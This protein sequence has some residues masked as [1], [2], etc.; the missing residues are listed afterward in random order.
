[1]PFF[2]EA[3]RGVGGGGNDCIQGTRLMAPKTTLRAFRLDRSR[4]LHGGGGLV[5]GLDFNPQ[6]WWKGKN[7]PG[8]PGVVWGLQRGS[9]RQRG[10]TESSEAWLYR[11]CPGRVAEWWGKGKERPC[12]VMRHHL[13]RAQDSGEKAP[14]NS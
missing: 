14:R 13:A 1:M 12:G 11:G 9:E 6:R 8:L 10:W 2:P 3:Q 4:R 7:M 5:N